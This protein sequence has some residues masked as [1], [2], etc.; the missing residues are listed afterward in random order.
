MTRGFLSI[1]RQEKLGHGDEGNR[2]HVNLSMPFLKLKVVKMK[3]TS[4]DPTDKVLAFYRDKLASYGTVARVQG[5][6]PGR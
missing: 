3:F 6:Q 2:A 1:R 4:D 5:R